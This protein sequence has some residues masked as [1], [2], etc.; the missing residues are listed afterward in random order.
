MRITEEYTLKSC[1]K[2]GHIHRK[3]GSSKNFV[4]PNCGYENRATLMEPWGLSSRRCGIPPLPTQLVMLYWTFTISQM[5]GN[6][7]VKSI[8][9]E[10]QF[11]ALAYQI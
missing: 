6:V 11:P 9:I 7:S 4:C 3:L 1:T 5:S 8:R 10:Y 2:C